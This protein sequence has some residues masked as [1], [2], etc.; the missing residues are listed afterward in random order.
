MRKHRIGGNDNRE[1]V[2]EKSRSDKN[3]DGTG[4]GYIRH[5]QKSAYITIYRV[6]LSDGY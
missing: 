5:F 2:F 6:P 1:K 4:L 3:L